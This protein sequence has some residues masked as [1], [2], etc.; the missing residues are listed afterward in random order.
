MFDGFAVAEL[1]LHTGQLLAALATPDNDL[2]HAINVGDRVCLFC[3]GVR[4]SSNFLA[5]KLTWNHVQRLV[6]ER[7]AHV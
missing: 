3:N 7:K 2:D 4:I 6:V 1:G 5:G